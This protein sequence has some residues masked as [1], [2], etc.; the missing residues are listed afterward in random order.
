VPEMTMRLKRTCEAGFTFVELLVV[1]ALVAI[2]ATAVMPLAKVT[3]QRQREI[4][5]RRALRE[6]RTAIDHYK[7]AADQGQIPPTSIRAGSEGYPPDL[8]TLVV[9][10]R[11]AGEGGTDRK[12]KFLRRIPIDPMTRS[13]EWGLRAYQDKPDSKSWGGQ[14]VYDVYSKSEGTALDGTKYADW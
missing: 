10:V 9:G 14:D 3:M 1:T 13:A 5:L 11:A 7:D 2:L 8:E 12:L 6:L 4:E